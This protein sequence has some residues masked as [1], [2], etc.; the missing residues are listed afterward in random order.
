MRNRRAL[1]IGVA[2]IALGALGACGNDDDGRETGTATAA[3]NSN[4]AA[5]N[6]AGGGSE[7]GQAAA[8]DLPQ[9]ADMASVEY[10]LNKYTECLDL[11]PGEDYSP[12][13]PDG[14]AWG[15]EEAADPSWGI[16]QR[17]V[18]LDGHDRPIALLT[19]PDMKTFQTAALKDGHAAFL[20][21]RDFAVVP[22]GDDTIRE[23][24]P[25]GLAFLTCDPDFAVPSGHETRPG[26]VEGC[27]L[28]DYVPSD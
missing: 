6:G 8:D 27:V 10:Y 19:V 22:V 12:S 14:T 7:G 17:A 13:G 21:G 3:G 2:L 4:N 16:T 15:E 9:A 25:S 11:T 1:T 23:L 20:V 24:E 18:C 28:T 26:A 5:G